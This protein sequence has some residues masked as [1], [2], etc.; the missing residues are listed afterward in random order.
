[1]LHT[2]VVTF[3]LLQKKLSKKFTNFGRILGPFQ[4]ICSYLTVVT[5]LA[6]FL[7]V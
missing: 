3:G 2:T 1:M 5:V 4:I 6:V 7:Y